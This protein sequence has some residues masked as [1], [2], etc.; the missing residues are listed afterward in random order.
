[1]KAVRALDDI[2]RHME[3]YQQKSRSTLRKLKLAELFRLSD[4]GSRVAIAGS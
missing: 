1:V 3:G 4:N 2:L